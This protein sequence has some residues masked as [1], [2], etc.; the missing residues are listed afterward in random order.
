MHYECLL[1]EVDDRVATIT[2]NRP[3]RM[4]A[5]SQKLV[6]EIITA[7]SSADQD[8][9]VRVLMIRGAG[10]K[11]FSAGFDVKESLDQPKRGLIEWRARMQKDLRFSYSV[12]DCTKP[13]IAIIEGFCLA[14]ALEFAM[15]CDVRYAAD[16]AKLGA[17]EARFSNG[18]ATMIMPWLIGQRSRALIYSGDIISGKEAYRLGLVDMV[19]PK[20][21]LGAEALKF[22]RRMSRVS[23]ECLQWNKRAINHTFEAMGLRSAIQYGAEACAILDASGSPEAEM[24][25]SIRRSKGLSAAIKWRADQFAPYE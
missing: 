10:G 8:P 9:H 24:Y 14:G 19:F 23:L 2:L 18:I 7:I 4:N 22:A 16:D 3:D 25:D 17:V 11:A 1:Y 5:L 15:C 20:A 6:E 21:E 13:V 12:W